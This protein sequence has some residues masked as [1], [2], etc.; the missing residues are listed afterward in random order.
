MAFVAFGTKPCTIKMAPLVK[1]LDRRG[2][3]AKILYSGQHWSP[4]LYNE[5]FDDLEL[6]YPDYDLH[7]GEESRSLAQLTALILS[8]TEEVLLDLKPDIVLTHGDT[9]TSLAVSMASYMSMIPVGHVEAGLRTFSKE[10]FPEQLNTRV[11]DAASDLYFAPTEKNAQNLRNEGFPQD[12]IAVVG[13]TVVDIA[14]WAATKRPDVM[15]KYG[16]ERPLVYLS[17]HRRE[18]TMSKDRFRG[19]FEAA[20]AMEDVNFF[21]SMRPGT[22]QAL[23]KYGMMHALMNAKN[24]YLHD[25]IPSY[26]ET[27]SLVNRCDAIITDSGSMQEE[28]AALH[29]PCLAARYVTDRPETVEAGCN[30]LVGLKKDEII[31]AFRMVLETPEVAERMRAVPCP[32]GEGDTSKRI[33]DFVEHLGKE[34]LW[35]FEKGIPQSTPQ[36]HRMERR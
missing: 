31:R 10:P 21:V 11:S 17:I 9:T 27:I 36:M 2:H 30:L 25:S 18:T 28:A 33:V 12:R 6:R 14:K 7:C 19:P 24:I 16:L 26:V 20:M 5:L 8:R 22:R 13:N 32:Y 4:N 3:D 29:I 35:R 1:E 34:G 15:K 23:E